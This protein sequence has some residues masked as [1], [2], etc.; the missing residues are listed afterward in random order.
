MQDRRDRCVLLIGTGRAVERYDELYSAAGYCRVDRVSPGDWPGSGQVY[1][2]VHIV[3]TGLLRLP[4]LAEPV[5][6]LG[7][8][9][10]LPFWPGLPLAELERFVVHCESCDL[11][12]MLAYPPL[13]GP[14]F[15]KLLHAVSTGLV[16]T[17]ERVELRLPGGDE[18]FRRGVS[19]GPPMAPACVGLAFAALLLDAPVTWESWSPGAATWSSTT[20]AGIEVRVCSAEGGSGAEFA[21]AGSASTLLL[22]AD[23]GTHRLRARRGDVEKELDRFEQVDL[24]C[25]T[26]KAA[27]LFLDNRT[28]NV[29]PG[30]T[31]LLLGRVF[32]AA[33]KALLPPAPVEPRP[34]QHEEALP[35]GPPPR[36]DLYRKRHGRPGKD[37]V[38]PIWEAKFNIEAACNQDCLFCF[39]RDDDLQLTDLAGSPELLGR[40]TAEGVEGVMFSGREPTLNHSLPEYIAMAKAAGMRNVT[41]E[42]NALLFAD[43]PLVRRCRE[44]GLDSAFVSFHSARAETVALLTR[45]EDSFERTLQG[46]R[47]LIEAGVDVE[48]NCVIKRHK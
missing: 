7:A 22:S 24:Y 42:T 48:L 6:A 32:E 9:V 3:D 36:Y 45:T 28:R 34:P 46:I 10:A 20:A 13:Y 31:G 30:H 27:G 4:E 29:I 1:H 19:S 38:L 40:L 25:A 17:V 39:A 33:R 41:V 21:V 18:E 16:G 11:R 43:M 2:L 37:P 26:T 47:N 35:P 5:A 15:H 23:G 14:A 12:L 44:A 8:P